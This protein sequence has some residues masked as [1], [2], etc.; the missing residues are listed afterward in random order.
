MDS[1]SKQSVVDKSLPVKRGRK[2]LFSHLE[3]IIPE[4]IQYGLVVVVVD[5]EKKKHKRR[6]PCT[7]Q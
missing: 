1:Q 4:S 6:Q 7:T 2:P 3:F 5:S